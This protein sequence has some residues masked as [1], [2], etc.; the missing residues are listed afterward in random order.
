MREVFHADVSNMKFC[1]VHNFLMLIALAISLVNGFSPLSKSTTAT[2]QDRMRANHDIFTLF[3]S[4]SNDDS[5][6]AAKVR[7]SGFDV[8]KNQQSAETTTDPLDSALTLLTSD[9][10]S[11]IL[12]AIGLTLLVIERL[13]SPDASPPGLSAGQYAEQLGEETRSNLIAV[14]ATGSVLLN[15]LSK[16]DVTSAIAEAVELDGV[17]LE[18]P[19]FFGGSD[20]I[21]QNKETLQWAMDSMLTA[22]PAK[23]IVM[24]E[25]IDQKWQIL[26]IAGTVPAAARVNRPNIV[27]ST[28]I[29]DR[30]EKDTSKETYLPTLQALPAKAE[31]TYLPANAQEVL[32]LSVP[33][34]D[35]SRTTGII[36]GS[37]R[38]K[39][40][41][42]RNVAWCKTLANRLGEV[43]SRQ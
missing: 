31:F 8:D 24:L 9:V 32:I 27:Q 6:T 16:L 34:L 43:W 20:S 14:L 36:L 30:F 5:D 22:T 38:A 40:F 18:E 35:R 26:S 4:S 37:N 17:K 23:S 19:I 2:H 28:P 42:P 3:Q 39:S 7:F 41:T 13:S 11:I 25:K 12:G 33:T 15:G 29:L 1:K 10:G 21:Q